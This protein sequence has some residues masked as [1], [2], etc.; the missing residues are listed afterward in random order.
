MSQRRIRRRHAKRRR[1]TVREYWRAFGVTRCVTFV[2][3]P[4]ARVT[5]D[6]TDQWN[7]ALRQV[8]K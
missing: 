4:N 1:Q 3:D 5:F 7:A 8:A 2:P 6:V